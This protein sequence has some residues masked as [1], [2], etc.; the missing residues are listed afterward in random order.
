MSVTFVSAD[1][2][3]LLGVVPAGSRTHLAVLHTIDGGATWSQRPAPPVTLGAGGT[4]NSAR[5]RF[6]DPADGWIAAPLARSTG[7]FPRVLW[8]THDGGRSWHEVA[9]PGGGSIAALEAADGVVHLATLAWRA[10]RVRLYSTPAATDAWVPAP[11]TL[12]IGAGP[13][14]SA[15]MSLHGGAGWVVENDRMVVAG[16]RLTSGSWQP[17]TPPC[18]DALGAGVLAASSTTDLVAVCDEGVWGPPPPGVTAGPWLFTSD[19]AG[20]SFTAVGKVVMPIGSVFAS[21]VATPPGEPQVVVVGGRLGLAA[22]FDGGHTWRTV[23]RAPGG[24]GVR[25]VGFTTASQGVAIATGAKATAT[26]LMSH[27]GGATWSPVTLSG[28]ATS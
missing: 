15:D 1:V 14:P 17:W 3:W 8:S 28:A 9:V 5:I 7:P 20:S 21:S 18:A 12:P 27:D 25:V 22:T 4:A 13:V 23:Y 2:G 24:L 19:D 26:L 16:A 10:A 11:T 6:A